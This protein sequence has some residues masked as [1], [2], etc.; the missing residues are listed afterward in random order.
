MSAAWRRYG[1]RVSFAWDHSGKPL[2][3]VARTVVDTRVR[4]LVSV[5]S[6]PAGGGP[7]LGYAGVPDGMVK[8]LQM[9]DRQRERTGVG[10]A[11]H[12]CAQVTAREVFGRHRLPDAD[13]VAVTGTAAQ[14]AA[15]PT[16][17]ALVLPYRL[18][19][20]VAADPAWR[21]RMSTGERQ[22]CET[23]IRRRKLRIEVAAD[24]TDFDFFYDRIHLP[25][26]RNRHGERARSESRVRAYECLF[27]PGLLM[28]VTDGESRLAGALAHWSQ[29]GRT[30][31]TPR[32]G[33][34]LDGSAELHAEGLLRVMS[35]LILDW[36]ERHG[37]QHVDFS[38][39]EA[40][41][42]NGLYGYKRRLTPHLV[43]PP[44]H[45]ANLAL[46]WHV[47]RDTAEVRDFLVANPVLEDLGDGTLRAV[48]F[49]D[50]HRPARLDIPHTCANVRST[51]LVD[52]DDLL[53]K[54]L[55]P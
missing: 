5:V 33:G 2:P 30:A 43:P 9:L 38:G 44:D 32:L 14:V 15:L 54:E 35:Y 29:G 4:R 28:I 55:T 46:W 1:A 17:S 36:A 39:L 50:A 20:V 3:V 8:I 21:R 12:V 51:R 47:R 41:L 25:T 27:R 22:W 7:S 31:L 40:W 42:G 48:Y 34:V 53:D 13:L 52:L 24:R 19:A 26:M 49:H 45:R 6:R 23:R 37:V 16:R 10:T 18:H 11:G